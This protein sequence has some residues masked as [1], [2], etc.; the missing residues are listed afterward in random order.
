V[1]AALPFVPREVFLTVEIVAMRASAWISDPAG[2]TPDENV[3][4]FFSLAMQA[5]PRATHEATLGMAFDQEYQPFFILNA[6]LGR[7]AGGR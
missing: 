2:V 1:V 5:T 3:D 6:N 4:S 7:A